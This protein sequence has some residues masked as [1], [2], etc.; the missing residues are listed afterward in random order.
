MVACQVLA[1][2]NV[3][4]LTSLVPVLLATPA[5]PNTFFHLACVR[6]CHFSWKGY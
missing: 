6:S 4:I 5:K 3:L 2:T 1:M